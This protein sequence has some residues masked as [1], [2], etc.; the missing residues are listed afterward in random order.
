V[1]AAGLNL[2]FPGEAARHA[3]LVSG[4]VG[5]LVQVLLFTIVKLAAS[6]NLIT[7]WGVGT[8]VRFVGLVV[9]A[10]VIARATQIELGPALVGLATFFFA[11]TLLEPHFLKK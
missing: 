8:V 10:F 4:V 9:Y 1:L 5:L 6:D 11:C 2:V 7:A 3:L